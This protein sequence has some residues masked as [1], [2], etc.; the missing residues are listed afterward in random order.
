MSF[1]T[2]IIEELSVLQQGKNCCRRALLLGLFWDGEL[3]PTEE[4]VTAR[5]RTE[6]GA[7]LACSLLRSRFSVETEVEP[8]AHAGR[9]Y[10]QVSAVCPAV[11]DAL[12]LADSEDPRMPWD[13]LGFRCGNCRSEFLRG[14][15]I[16]TAS[17]NDPHKGYHMEFSLRH[18]ARADRLVQLLESVTESPKRVRRGERL[19][20]YYKTNSAISDLIY[21]MGGTK[22]SFTVANTWVERDIRNYENRATN[23]VATNIS[24]AVEASQRQIAAIKR[25]REV[26]RL[27]ALPEE[28]RITAKLRE[29]NEGASLSEL[30]RMHE[31][32]ISKSG[33]NQR[34][35]KL[36]QAAEEPEI[37]VKNSYDKEIL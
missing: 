20:L 24:K 8:F 22:S 29:E 9:W 17:V 16:A 19:G 2:D 33:L 37:H 10:F 5:F 30:A 14:V 36:L 12:A 23:C 28:L 7:Q 26:G 11:G 3:N 4:R 34:L 35:N 32:P 13:L 6:C 15:F 21:C 27:E 1:T 25:L 31:P 18:P